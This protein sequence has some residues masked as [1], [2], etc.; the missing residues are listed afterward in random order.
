MTEA[1]A[2]PANRHVL[3]ADDEP[4]IGR[5]LQLK[6]ESGPYTVSLVGRRA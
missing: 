2:A 6:L 3:V 1:S 5:I 4:H